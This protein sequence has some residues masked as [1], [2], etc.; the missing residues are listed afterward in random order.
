LGWHIGIGLPA[1]V[2]SPCPGLFL[3]NKNHL[4]DVDRPD[5]RAPFIGGAAKQS[6]LP[7]LR[8]L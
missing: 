7:A 5:L 3:L 2:K 1:Q 6:Y 8:R 4:A